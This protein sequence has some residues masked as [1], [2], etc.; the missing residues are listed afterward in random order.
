MESLRI[1][2]LKGKDVSG[3]KGLTH[4]KKLFIEN[5]AELEDL[6]PLAEM[7]QLE[8]LILGETKKIDDYSRLSKL[9]N[10]KVLGI[11]RYR[12]EYDG[13]KLRIKST[14]F[15]KD[16]PNLEWVDLVDCEVE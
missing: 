4:L 3:I 15:M 6:S 9:Q 8:V 14:D 5:A 10:L 13:A 2:W 16:M 12:S 7:R 1:K 11:C